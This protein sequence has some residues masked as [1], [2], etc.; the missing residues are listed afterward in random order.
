MSA[1]YEVEVADRAERIMKTRSGYVVEEPVYDR[2][3]LDPLLALILLPFL[4][5]ILIAQSLYSLQSIYVKPRRRILITEIERTP[6]GY[7]ILEYEV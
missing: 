6:T 3:R 5:L 2:F 1:D 7:R 4:P